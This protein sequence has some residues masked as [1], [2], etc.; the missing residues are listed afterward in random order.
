MTSTQRKGITLVEV[1]IVVGV[2]SLLIGL[3]MPAVQSVRAAASRTQCSN[4][5]RQIAL[6]LH[7]Y[8][9][10]EG[11]LPPA[12]DHTLTARFRYMNW[13]AR[14]LPYIEQDA[15][16]QDAIRATGIDPNMGHNPPHLNQT[17]PVKLFYCP[18]DPRGGMAKDGSEPI[19]ITDYLGCSGL[20]IVSRDGVLFQN[21]QVRLVDV[22]DGTSNTLLVG[23]RPPPELRTPNWYANS[24]I[25]GS[26][27][28]ASHVG[29]REI[30]DDPAVDYVCPQPAH[31]GPATPKSPCGYV[32]FWSFH[33]NG[34]N[35][36][37]CDGS[38]HFLT[39]AADPLL[40]ALATRAG[41]DI[42]EIP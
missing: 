42:A 35:F 11:S 25:F 36:V 38:V 24:G 2:I 13:H 23:E 9:D 22:T 4:N 14:I 37:F 20:N 16:W 33:P 41:G 12:T 17:R 40:P 26:G 6:G 30:H 32:H 1:L 34:A 31:F 29:V 28:L 3:L 5:L 18:S 21:S 8:H 7:Q 15:L 10:A 27:S 19:A 39:Y